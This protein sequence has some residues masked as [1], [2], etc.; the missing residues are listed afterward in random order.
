MVT[1]AVSRMVLASSRDALRCFH[2]D[3]PL[4]EEA[5]EV[6]HKIPDLRE[7]SV[8]IERDTS[9]PSLM[10]PNLTNLTI[11]YDRDGDWSPM[12]HG[13]TLGKLEAVEFHSG[14]EQISDFLET[15][16][17]IALAAFAHNTISRFRLYTSC[18]WNPNYSS[19]LTFTQLTELIIEFSCSG[20]CSSRV[21]DDIIMDWRE[22]YQS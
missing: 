2:V 5:R 14:S 6:I 9:L 1:A 20:G 13:A 8:I 17:R 16:E 21:D 19:L 7:L 11:T 10:L 15:F 3:S 4:T 12:F 18:S 22:Q